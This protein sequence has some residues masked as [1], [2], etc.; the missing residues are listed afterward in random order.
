MTTKQTPTDLDKPDGRLI[1]NAQVRYTVIYRATCS[2]W[3]A[4][5]RV[6]I[7]PARRDLADARQV[8]GEGEELGIGASDAFGQWVDITDES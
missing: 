8:F 5:E 2:R 7:E 1:G 3:G 4:P 6:S